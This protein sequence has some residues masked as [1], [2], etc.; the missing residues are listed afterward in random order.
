MLLRTTGNTTTYLEW[1]ELMN[2][3]EMQTSVALFRLTKYTA[4]IQGVTWGLNITVED[5]FLGQK[6]FYQHGSYS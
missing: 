4:N 6:S 1:K 3:D 2:S 5:N